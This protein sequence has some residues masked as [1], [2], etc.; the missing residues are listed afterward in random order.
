M[1]RYKAV[2]TSRDVCD[3]LTTEDSWQRSAATSLQISIRPVSSHVWRFITRQ[4][5]LMLSSI[6]VALLSCISTR[7]TLFR[8]SRFELEI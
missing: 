6:K 3:S 1:R 7:L 5:V 8:E 4:S 2:F